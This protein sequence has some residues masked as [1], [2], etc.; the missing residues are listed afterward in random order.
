MGTRC[1]I[2]SGVRVVWRRDGRVATQ[3]GARSACILTAAAS[4]TLY[5]SDY[6][7]ISRSCLRRRGSILLERSTSPA[8]TDGGGEANGIGAARYRL[9]PR[10]SWQRAKDVLLSPSLLL[11]CVDALRHD[12]CSSAILSVSARRKSTAAHLD[13]NQRSGNPVGREMCCFRLDNVIGP[14][15]WKS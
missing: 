12:S 8:L 11:R 9:R 4:A 5:Q 1:S 14:R 10:K 13:A 15:E 2:R 3:L 6:G 7:A